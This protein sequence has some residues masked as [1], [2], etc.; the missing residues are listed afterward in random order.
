[1]IELLDNSL[2][3]A[4]LLICLLISAWNLY[5]RRNRGWLLLTLFYGCYSIALTY[6]LLYLFLRGDQ[7][8]AVR[9][10]SDLSWISGILFLCMLLRLV[11]PEPVPKRVRVICAIAPVIAIASCVLFLQYGSYISNILYAAVMSWMGWLALSVFLQ[12]GRYR[13][14]GLSAAVNFFVQYG[15]WIASCF[16]SGNQYFDPYLLLDVL[17]SF[18]LLFILLAYRKAVAE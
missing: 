8:P 1:M 17:V 12:P 15:A 10:V 3:L 13:I 2:Q 5:R 4:I 6:W 14:F 16:W 7:P 9:L 18:S 11:R